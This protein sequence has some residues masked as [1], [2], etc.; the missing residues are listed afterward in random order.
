MSSYDGE[1]YT[2]RPVSGST[3]LITQ[4]MSTPSARRLLVEPAES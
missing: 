2:V 3:V 4:F 1:L